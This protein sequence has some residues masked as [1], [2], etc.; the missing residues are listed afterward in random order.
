M[1]A[2]LL[3]V[4]FSL[5]VATPTLAEP[6][7]SWVFGDNGVLDY[8]LLEEGISDPSLF[9][10]P[11]PAEDPTINLV[12]GKRYRVTVMNPD[13]H[14]IDIIAA[15]P[16]QDPFLDIRLLSMAGG[17]AGTFENDPEVDFFDA[18]LSANSYI[19][20]TLTQALWDAMRDTTGGV[21][22]MPGYRC[23]FHAVTMRGA[24]HVT[25]SVPTATPTVTPTVTVTPTP[26]VTTSL[27]ATPS[28]TATA[29]PTPPP[30]TTIPTA[31]P[32]A[33]PHPAVVVAEVLTGQRPAS[34]SRDD[35]NTDG[36]VDA[37]DAVANPHGHHHG[38]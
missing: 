2:G 38:H 36:H 33:T 37:A 16:G 20:F 5:A 1:R 6:D 26:S 28:L 32:T 19:E 30:T 23:D 29:T 15:D 22:R 35:R 7:F 27:T 8:V 21:E 3:A 11:F 34:Q 10:G 4:L 18:G 24:F 13:F 25:T 12:V 31:T 14:P 17:G 9:A